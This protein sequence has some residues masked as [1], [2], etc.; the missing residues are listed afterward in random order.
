VHRV[1]PPPDEASA[2]MVASMAFAV[3]PVNRKRIMVQQVV[4]A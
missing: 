1:D 2:L 4:D 3:E